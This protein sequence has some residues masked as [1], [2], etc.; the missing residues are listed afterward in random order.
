MIPSDS[1]SCISS[2]DTKDHAI[3]DHASIGFE[4]VFSLIMLDHFSFVMFH[5]PSL[6]HGKTGQGLQWQYFG[7]SAL[8]EDVK[9]V[10]LQS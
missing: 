5:V 6:A 8:L 7:C 9:S 2:A 3:L 1:N 10:R 4:I